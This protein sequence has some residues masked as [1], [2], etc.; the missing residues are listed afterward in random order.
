MKLIR[1]RDQI[2]ASGQAWA[3]EFPASAVQAIGVA[4]V[5]GAAALT[6]PGATT[7]VTTLSRAAIA[8]LALLQTGAA[9]THLR[10]AEAA[11]TVPV[12]LA[13]LAAAVIVG[14]DMI[15]TSRTPSSWITHRR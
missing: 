10:R 3:A 5:L 8:G 11:A 14:R 12:N 9:I 1:S 7:T 4:E 13:L 6:L 2:V 15:Q